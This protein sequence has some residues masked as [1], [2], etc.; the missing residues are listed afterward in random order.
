VNLIKRSDD[1]KSVKILEA[2]HELKSEDGYIQTYLYDHVEGSEAYLTST[3]SSMWP[4][5]TEHYRD[6]EQTFY[7]IGIKIEDLYYHVMELGEDSDFEIYINIPNGPK[8]Q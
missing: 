3:V 6:R 8:G 5:N 1:S 4:P 7:Q 2:L